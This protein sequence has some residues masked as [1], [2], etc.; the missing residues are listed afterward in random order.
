M[1]RS[2]CKAVPSMYGWSNSTT[3]TAPSTLVSSRHTCDHR[4]LRN[5]INSR[6]TCRG[7]R[8]A[9]GGVF[10]LSVDHKSR[11]QL[12]MCPRSREASTCGKMS[13]FSSCFRLEDPR[14]KIWRRGRAGLF[15]IFGDRGCNPCKIRC[16]P[17]EDIV[18]AKERAYVCTIRRLL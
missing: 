15:A 7:R 4:L 3:H 6:P 17:G 14:R 9:S 8:S 11:Y 2:S 13:I 10:I 5:P 1:V 18:Q 12:C 16:K